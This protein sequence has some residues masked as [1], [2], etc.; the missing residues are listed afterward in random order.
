MNQV[1]VSESLFSIY[2]IL[3]ISNIIALLVVI[4]VNRSKNESFESIDFTKNLDIDSLRVKVNNLQTELNETRKKLVFCESDYAKCIARPQQQYNGNQ[5]SGNSEPIRDYGN[6]D[7]QR[8]GLVYNGTDR[9]PLYGRKKYRN[10]NK[11]E[12]YIVDDSRNRMQ[13]PFKTRGDE[14]L[15][16]GDIANVPTVGSLTVEMYDV[17]GF[18]YV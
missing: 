5:N 17:G 1:C 4:F 6:I 12:Y 9:F 13:L 2:T 10:G 3:F 15:D 18:R 14:E 11:W 7:Y 8:I 16:T